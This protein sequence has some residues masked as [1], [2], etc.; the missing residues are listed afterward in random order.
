MLVFDI[1]LQQIY[2]LMKTESNEYQLFKNTDSH[3][4]GDCINFPDLESRINDTDDDEILLKN[5][6]DKG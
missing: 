1:G 4:G 3:G 2:L 5:A 6:I